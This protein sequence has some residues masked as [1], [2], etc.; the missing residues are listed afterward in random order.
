MQGRLHC[1][2]RCLLGHQRA[3]GVQRVLLAAQPFGVGAAGVKAG[4][5][6]TLV[7]DGQL[8]CVQPPI[9]ALGAFDGFFAALRAGL[10]GR[11][12]MKSSLNS[13][14]FLANRRSMCCSCS[15]WS[16]LTSAAMA[17]SAWVATASSLPRTSA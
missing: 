12:S 6:D 7:D 8:G 1:G 5:V 17:G 2:G 15:G 14:S 3:Q 13:A 16:W 10:L 9:Q 11:V 4:G